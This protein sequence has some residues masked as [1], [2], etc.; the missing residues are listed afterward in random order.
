MVNLLVANLFVA[1]LLVTNLFVVNLLVANLFLVDL[2]VAA[3]FV[4]NQYLLM[5]LGS[6]SP[7]QKPLSN[8]SHT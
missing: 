2:L 4:V 5:M 7:P 8:L 3:L 6:T 1:N